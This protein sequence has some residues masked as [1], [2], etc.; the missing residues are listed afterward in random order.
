MTTGNRP[1]LAI[2]GGNR[3]YKVSGA[4]IRIRGL[5]PAADGERYVRA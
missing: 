5:A 4:G 2:I 1:P 3:R